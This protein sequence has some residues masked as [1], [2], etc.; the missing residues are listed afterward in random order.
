MFLPFES[1]PKSLVQGRDIKVL[2]AAAS[3]VVLE[4]RASK[5]C[6]ESLGKGIRG[7]RCFLAVVSEYHK[8]VIKAIKKVAFVLI[9]V[10]GV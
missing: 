2:A 1:V 10:R 9:F 6:R 4:G 8:L 3:V 7:N 5:Y